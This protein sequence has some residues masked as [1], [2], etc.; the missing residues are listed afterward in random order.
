MECCQPTAAA[1]REDAAN[2]RLVVADGHLR[3]LC[4]VNQS[5]SLGRDRRCRVQRAGLLQDH[6]LSSRL[7]T[8][9]GSTPSRHLAPNT[10]LRWT[11][12]RTQLAS[13]TKY[14]LDTRSSCSSTQPGMSSTPARKQRS[15]DTS[16]PA[17][18]SSASIRHATPNIGGHGMGGSSAPN[19][20]AT[21]R[22]SARRSALRTQVI[23][24]RRACRRPGSAL[25]NG[26]IS[27]AT[28]GGRFG[29]WRRSTSRVI[30][31]E[32][33]APTTRSRGVN[34]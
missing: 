1:S 20:R 32:R 30:P 11:A 6:R 24:R 9:R 21:P 14:W 29:Y 2:R 5:R 22:S 31:E 19:S 26:T 17:A 25:T 15:N 33:W 28:D 10:A 23:R 3:P 12:P 8:A 16:D 18:G 27:A 13:A 7:D 34:K 4:R